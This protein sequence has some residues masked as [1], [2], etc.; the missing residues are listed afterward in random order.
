M[1]PSEDPSTWI[2][3]KRNNSLSSGYNNLI[4][5]LIL[6]T[7]FIFTWNTLIIMHTYF[8]KIST[9][10]YFS[11]YLEYGYLENWRHLP[12]S[13][14]SFLWGFCTSLSNFIIQ[15]EYREE[16]QADSLLY[17]LLVGMKQIVVELVYSRRLWPSTMPKQPTSLLTTCDPSL[18]P[19]YIGIRK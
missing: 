18:H 12:I 13:L 19:H 17:W 14:S 2:C 4:R 5:H 16:S 6:T 7:R 11:K 10:L 8:K 15:G 3:K 9:L 1:W